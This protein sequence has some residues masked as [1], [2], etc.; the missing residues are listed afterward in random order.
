VG[1][2]SDLAAMRWT[3]AAEHRVLAGAFVAN[4]ALAFLLGLRGAAMLHASAVSVDGSTIAIAGGAGA[5]KTTLAGLFC[6]AGAALVSDD[7]LRVQP[8]DGAVTCHSGGTKLR[9]RDHGWSALPEMEGE[10]SPD[11]RRLVAPTFNAGKHRLDGILLPVVEPACRT[12]VVRRLGEREALIELTRHPRWAGWRIPGPQRA[13]FAATAACAR[14]LP[15][16]EARL[17][18]YGTPP[19]GVVEQLL[20]AL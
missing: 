16:V 20:A 13:Q 3:V 5:G 12:P 15:I 18:R 9:V 17:P 2:S 6:A 7:A 8:E 14:E 11:G 4:P 10:Q 19:E 1:L